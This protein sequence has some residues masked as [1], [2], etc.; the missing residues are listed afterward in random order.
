MSLFTN[1]NENE[2]DPDRDLATHRILET[3]FNKVHILQEGPHGFWFCHLDKGG[4]PKGI[5]GAF[6]TYED[7]MKA[8]Q[9]YYLNN[10]K[11]EIRKEIK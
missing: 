10:K 1:Y 2:T 11:E 4:S 6:T 7:A 5:Q 8:V 3:K 9:S